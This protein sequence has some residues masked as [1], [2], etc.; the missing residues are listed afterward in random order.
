MD[1]HQDTS[2]ISKS[3][4]DEINKCPAKY[5][6]KYLDPDR[7]IEREKSDALIF[8]GAYHSLNLEPN[9]FEQEYF[10]MPKLKGEGSLN[11][12]RDLISS[13][14][15]KEW[16]STDAYN[17]IQLMRAALMRHPKVKEI[18][19]APG[20]VERRFNWIDKSTGI[21]CKIKPDK[22]LINQ[23][24][25][26]DLKTTEDASTRASGSSAAKYRYHVQGAFYTDGLIANGINPKGFI[27]IFQEKS[28]PYLVSVQY[29][30]PAD[31]ELGRE[32]YMEDLKKYAECIKS[33]EWPGYD[34]IITPLDLPAWVYN[35]NQ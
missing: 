21:S 17:E 3:G 10:I 1:Y 12:R 8:G 27:F 11:T 13:N 15:G 22:Y 14:H 9:K 29:L 5:Y 25:V 34:D 19:E 2:H 4:L 26:I 23:Q 24:Y 28:Y 6:A 30:K 7:V 35:V 32:I 20:Y 33:G 31:I 16:I 18:L